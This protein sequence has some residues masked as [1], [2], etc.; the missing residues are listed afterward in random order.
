MA[1]RWSIEIA[2]DLAY[3]VEMVRKRN[4]RFQFP[5]AVIF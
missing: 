1:R 2:I 5:H 4:V 3:I